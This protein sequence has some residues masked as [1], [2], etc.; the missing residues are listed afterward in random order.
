MPGPFGKCILTSVDHE[1]VENLVKYFQ[2]T[3][4]QIT[5]Y[6]LCFIII[7]TVLLIHKSNHPKCNGDHL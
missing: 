1:G 3:F 6:L 5:F 7:N 2:I 4:S